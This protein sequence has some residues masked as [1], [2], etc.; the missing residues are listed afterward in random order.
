MAAFAAQIKARNFLIKLDT[1][2]VNP[3][4]LGALIKENLLDFVA[5]DFKTTREKEKIF[6]RSGIFEAF[7]ESLN[8]LVQNSVDFIV[9]TT[10]HSEILGADDLAKMREILDK[11]GY[12]KP[13]FLQHF[14]GDKKT[15]RPLSP[16]DRARF[17]GLK[18]VVVTN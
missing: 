2:G 18:N 1:N 11:N 17:A 3:S 15:L 16:H 14:V 5:L 4:A 13:H 10:L 7:L 12:T 9:R 8:L 6:G